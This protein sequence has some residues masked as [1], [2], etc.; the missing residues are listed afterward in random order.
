MTSAT[1]FKTRWEA[2][3]YARD[4]GKTAAV[5]IGYQLLARHLHACA[6][7]DMALLGVT[8]PAE[9]RPYMQPVTGGTDEERKA[10][11]DAFAARHGVKAGPD[12][13]TGTYRAVLS[14]GPC[15]Y[16][17]YMIPD[18]TMADRLAALYENVREAREAA[19]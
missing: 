7:E 15:S 16:V 10:R 17:A 2:D 19:A 5:A 12:D 14:F 4:H 13:A 6:A 1:D 18:R 9:P 3:E 11:V 8:L